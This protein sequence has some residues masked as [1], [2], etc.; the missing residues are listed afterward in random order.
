MQAGRGTKNNGVWID[1]SHLGAE[2]VERNFPGTVRRCRDMG[3]DLS[4]EPVEVLPTAHFMMGGVVI[5]AETRTSVEG[6]F[7]AGEDAGAVHGSNRLGG[8]GVAESTVF[9]IIAG[10][11]IP[12]LVSGRRR[13]SDAQF[14]EIAG[15]ALRP[16]GRANGERVFDLKA[17]LQALMWDKAGLVRNGRD[18]HEALQTLH[19]LGER[20]HRVSVQPSRR[21]NL[22][23]QEYLNL[24]NL[25]GVSR[26]IAV[27]AIAREDSRGSHFRTDFPSPDVRLLKNVYINRD[28]KPELRPVNLS[29]LQPS[30]V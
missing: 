12:Q 6:L 8:N 23:W 1:V 18:L 11:V 14:Q 24:E 17:E 22:D 28:M 15:R 29:R 30:G 4:K 10:A 13:A 7:A 16:L 3:F 26:L 5:D 21:Y 20:L 27:S 19:A 25:L 9:G 2:L